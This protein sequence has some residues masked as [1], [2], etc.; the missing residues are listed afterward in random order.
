MFS[1]FLIKFGFLN[2]IFT[3]CCLNDFN[4]FCTNISDTTPTTENAKVTEENDQKEPSLVEFFEKT[5]YM[6][7]ASKVFVELVLPTIRYMNKGCSFETA[8][9]IALIKCLSY[10]VRKTRAIY[11]QIFGDS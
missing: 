2:L 6:F 10:N 9:T 5:T 11:E 8:A 1:Q 7:I 3:M 4:L